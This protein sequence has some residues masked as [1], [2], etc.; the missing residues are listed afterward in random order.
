MKKSVYNIFKIG[1]KVELTSIGS[2]YLEGYI[3]EIFT[4]VDYSPSFE[5]WMEC[6]KENGENS[7]NCSCWQRF[8]VKKGKKIFKDVYSD[9]IKKI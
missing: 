1:D 9:E 2:N 7:K 4:V 3:G 5:E 8:K 6:K